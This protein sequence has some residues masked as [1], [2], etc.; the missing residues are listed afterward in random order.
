LAFL[1]EVRAHHWLPGSAV[2]NGRA[3]EHEQLPITAPPDPERV[4]P[5]TA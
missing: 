1:D 4:E 2:A 5:A 3:P